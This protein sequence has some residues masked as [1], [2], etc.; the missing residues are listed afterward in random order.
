MRK[1]IWPIFALLAA[2]GRGQ[3]PVQPPENLWRANLDGTP[4][5]DRPLSGEIAG[6]P[7]L[8]TAV[9]LRGETVEI[10]SADGG[11]IEIRLINCGAPAGRAFHFDAAPREF[12]GP[13]ARVRIGGRD[14]RDDF[15]LRL[16]VG[17]RAVGLY[18]CLPD[19]GWLAGSAPGD[20]GS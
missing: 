9:L 3:D 13:T 7:F 11:T 18:L 19:G 8:P 16:E 1:P 10:R 2:C 20:G 14:W 12:G 6:R 4:I 15:S 17:E 5:P